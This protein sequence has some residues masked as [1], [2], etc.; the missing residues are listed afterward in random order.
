MGKIGGITRVE[1]AG[2][3]IANGII[4]GV[5]ENDIAKVTIMYNYMDKFG[6]ESATFEIRTENNR[7]I[8]TFTKERVTYDLYR[9]EIREINKSYRRG[10]ITEKE[11][12]VAKND[13]RK[14]WMVGFH[15]MGY[16]NNLMWMTSEILTERDQELETWVDL[17]E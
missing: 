17:N 16:M 2:V 12:E 5:F 4:A 15:A 8:D 11:M 6:I 9:A 10:F 7:R 3:V 1:K 13:V 14:H